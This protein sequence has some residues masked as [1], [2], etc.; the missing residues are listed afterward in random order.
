MVGL[1][2]V[3][4]ASREVGMSRYHLIL[5]HI[6]EGNKLILTDT[7]SIIIEAARCRISRRTL[8]VIEESGILAVT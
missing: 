1:L 4:A 3:V 5:F 2:P 8:T 6:L 7:V